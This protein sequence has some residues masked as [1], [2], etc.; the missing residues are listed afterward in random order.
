TG[1]CLVAPRNGRPESRRCRKIPQLRVWL[2]FR[3]MKA[4]QAILG[5]L[6]RAVIGGG[7]RSDAYLEKSRHSTQIIVRHLIYYEEPIIIS[8][9]AVSCLLLSKSFN[10]PETS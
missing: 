7:E 8:L 5:R 9:V 3:Y 1:S 4:H 6:E 10:P 2:R